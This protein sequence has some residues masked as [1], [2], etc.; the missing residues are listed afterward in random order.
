MGVAGCLCG[1]GWKGVEDEAGGGVLGTAQSHCR[2]KR[3]RG[4]QV[5]AMLGLCS[6]GG[7]HANPEMVRGPRGPHEDRWPP[8]PL[9]H[10]APL[11]GPTCAT[12]SLFPRAPAQVQSQAFGQL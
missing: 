5:Q 3:H 8:D 2:K 6:N 9:H 7:R 1:A 12:S 11:P 4:P 10:P